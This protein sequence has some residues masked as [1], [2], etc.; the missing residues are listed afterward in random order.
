MTCRDDEMATANTTQSS[1]FFDAS[2]SPGLPKHLDPIA[3]DSDSDYEEAIELETPGAAAAEA[4]EA[5]EA[6]EADWPS[7]CALLRPV[8]GRLPG[9]CP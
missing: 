2:S 3:G 7:A 9:K 6:S 8:M 4:A 5:A 1:S